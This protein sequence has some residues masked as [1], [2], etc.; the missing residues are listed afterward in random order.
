MNF[1]KT[2]V[3]TVFLVCT[4]NKSYGQNDTSK[5]NIVVFLVDDLGYGDLS[6][7]G[8]PFMITPNIDKFASEGMKFTDLHSGSSICSPSRAALLTG[9]NPYRVGIWRLAGKNTHMRNSEVTI[10][11]VLKKK[12]YQTF[13][14]GK[15]H[16]SD[17]NLGQPTPGDQG[18]D[19]WIIRDKDKFVSNKGNVKLEDG[20]SC[21]KVVDYSIE[22]LENRDKKKPFFLEVSIREPHT[23]LSPPKKY[24]DLYDNERVR[25]L[26]KSIK[27]GRVLRPSYIDENASELA[28]YYYGTVTQL[29][30]AFGRLMQK[31]D[32]LEVRENTLVIFT[33]DN[34]SEHPVTHKNSERDR[35]WGT[36]GELRGM[37]R[38]LYEGG[39]RVAGL[40]RWP[41]VIASGVV[42]DELVS[43]VDFM[44]TICNIVEAEKPNVTL[45][46]INILP[47]LKGYPFNREKP[48]SWNICY[49]HAPNM[50]MRLGKY[51]LVGYFDPL[52]EGENLQ[53]WI[54]RANLSSF[55][56]YDLEKD[57]KQEVDLKEKEH[58]TFVLLRD[59]MIETFKGI[60]KEGP[61][62]PNYK[63]FTRPINE[64][65]Q[66]GI[67]G[68]KK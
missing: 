46:G 14:S 4:A 43:S 50:A 51:S 42:S 18:F 37:K 55:E 11:E 3:I 29:D 40:M 10:A 53:E 52:K 16:M 25:Y 47:V 63:A 7:Y 60:Q 65:Q 68:A 22:M 56:L 13:F 31:L 36:P 21:V 24:M 49:T 1:F 33:S 66:K 17:I 32:E 38:F 61:T 57:I 62:W 20:G 39:H 15:W 9:R 59:R 54:K 12:N 58:A 2:I 48:L 6:C 26:E 23:P 64:G 30:E 27:Y 45:D 5:P 8:H 41:E 34:G 35:S 28:R 19:K 67:P 44:P